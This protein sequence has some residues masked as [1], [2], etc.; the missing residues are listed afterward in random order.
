MWFDGDWE[1]PWNHEL[2][3]QLYLEL[4]QMQ[5][6]LVI[7]NRVGKSRPGVV[8]AGTKRMPNSGDYDTPEQ[9]IGNFDREFPRE[10]CMS[11][12]ESWSW[13]PNDNL[14]S[15]KQCLQTLLQVVGGDGNL[16]LDVGPM[17]DG[18]IEPRQVA[19]LED[20][21][22][23]LNK[24]GAGIYGTRGGPFKPARWG[25]ATC[26][27]DRIFLYVMNW[28][29][30]G[31]LQ[32]PAIPA[33]VVESK[34][35]S[36]GSASVRQDNSGIFIDPP[37]PDRDEIASVIELTVDGKA[38]DIKP[39]A[40]TYRS[41]S[42]ATGQRTTASN[43]FSNEDAYSAKC[44]TDDD[45]ATRWATD[46]GQNPAWLEVDFD[47]PT[48]IGRVVIDEPAEYQRIQAFELQYFDGHGWQNFH[49]G[50]TIG[51]DWSAVVTPITANR[52][53]LN[54]LKSSDSPTIR[55]FQLYGPSSPKSAKNTN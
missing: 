22:T 9:R 36:G 43:V 46:S 19:R 7:N 1:E 17:P 23:W 6:S 40:V 4:K 27:G 21:G 33:R 18:R 52:V 13:K 25:A 44:A 20:M 34:T 8:P 24:Y 54:I 31:P 10:T 50:A 53:R 28:P 38:V 15:V 16:L 45:Y 35:L 48:N 2:G 41:G 42:L 11:L 32:L 30:E 12:G 14:K 29:G 55:E 5:P 51:P 37:S 47:E 49:T 39:V 3:S 26:K